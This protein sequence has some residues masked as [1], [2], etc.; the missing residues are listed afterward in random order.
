M[1]SSTK[2]PSIFK[3]SLAKNPKRPANSFMLWT[4]IHRSILA[5]KN[6]G[7]TNTEIS[8]LLGH[9][10]NGLSIK[11][12]QKYKDKADQIKLEHKAHYP[13]Y[14]FCP[15]KKIKIIN[16]QHNK[17]TQQKKDKKQTYKKQIKGC[18]QKVNAKAQAKANTHNDN[19]TPIKFNDHWIN[20]NEEVD[21]YETI[22]LFYSNL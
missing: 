4:K 6:L 18:K 16:K 3:I 13:D 1:P 17:H 10:W 14:R 5:K 19:L 2:K 7:L 22:E 9:Y 20:Y 12:K 11:E 15:K 21:D 8:V